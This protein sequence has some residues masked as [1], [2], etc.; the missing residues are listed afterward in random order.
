MTTTIA[1]IA[2]PIAASGVGVIRVSGPATR[3]LIPRIF[4]FSD[5]AGGP[6]APETLAPRRLYHGFIVDGAARLDEVLLAFMPAPRSYTGEDVLEIHAHGSP[7]ILQTILELVLRQGAEMAA[8][9]EFTRRA[10]LNGK[11]DLTQAEAVADMISARSRPALAAAS[12][13]LAGG[14]RKQID[15]IR[16]VLTERLADLNAAIE[17]GDSDGAGAEAL[18]PI[19]EKELLRARALAPVENLI[20]RHDSDSQIRSGVRVA[21]IGRPNAGKSTLLNRLLGR[22]RAIVTPTPGTTRDVLEETLVFGGVPF[23]FSDT[24][25]IHTAA[26]DEVD[27]IGM[28]RAREAAQQA[29]AIL[30]MVDISADLPSPVVPDLGLDDGRVVVVANKIDRLSGPVEEALV[31]LGSAWPVVPVS[32][33]TGQGLPALQEL[34]AERF[35]GG[36]LR[37]DG[38]AVPAP[39][40]RQALLRTAAALRSALA[41][42]ESGVPDDLVAIDL[43]E[44]LAALGEITGDGADEAVLDSIFSRFCIGK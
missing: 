40:H 2:T 36:V 1:A 37:H 33:L 3:Q 41:A 16:E 18:D 17:F 9:G 12:D 35:A 8:P 22:E 14:L 38:R 28:A 32:A 5:P 27:R 39:R 11:M 34:L 4:R 20:A 24:A 31:P 10:F 13:Q 29:E 15:N 44:A 23:V 42:R 25:G 30:F 26:V 7:L 19:R 21:L 6:A 43:H